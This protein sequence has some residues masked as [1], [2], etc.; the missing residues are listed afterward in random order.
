MCARAVC[1]SLNEEICVRAGEVGTM[2]C[3][4]DDDGWDR[5]KRESKYEKAKDETHL[6]DGVHL[7]ALG[8][9]H[10]RALVLGAGDSLSS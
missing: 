7:I 10:L 4:R 8:Q 6:A 9:Q 2:H 3:V 1:L 5:K